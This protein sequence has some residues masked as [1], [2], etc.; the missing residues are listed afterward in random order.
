LGK[1]FAK[2]NSNIISIEELIKDLNIDPSKLESLL[3]RKRSFEEYIKVS[4]DELATKQKELKNIPA[5]N[6]LEEI[7]DK[8]ND[9]KKM[10][11]D[12]NNTIAQNQEI[13]EKETQVI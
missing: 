13:R 12:Y 6:D 3:E 8:R 9:S 5:F 1:D 4:N 7:V 11:D 10:L 2:N